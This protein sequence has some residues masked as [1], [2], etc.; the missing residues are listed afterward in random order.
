MASHLA[1]IFERT[2][3]EKTLTYE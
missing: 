1:H 3:F 2:S